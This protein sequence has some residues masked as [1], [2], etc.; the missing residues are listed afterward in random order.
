MCRRS[1]S[2]AGPEEAAAS[3]PLTASLEKATAPYDSEHG[4]ATEQTTFPA[5]D[6]IALK[7]RGSSDTMARNSVFVGHCEPGSFSVCPGR[8]RLFVSAAVGKSTATNST[9]W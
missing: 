2:E 6:P 4:A 8:M 3:R 7:S 9:D 5:I 1:P